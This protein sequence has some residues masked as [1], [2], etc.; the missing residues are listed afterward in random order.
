MYPAELFAI[1][2]A[3]QQILNRP[4]DMTVIFTDSLSAIQG[5]QKIYPNHPVLEQIKKDLVTLQNNRKQLH[6]V[7]IPSHVRIPGNEIADQMSKEACKIERSDNRTYQIPHS[8][9]KKC[10][11]E[12]TKNWIRRLQLLPNNKLRQANPDLSAR[13]PILVKRRDQVVLHCIRIGHIR[14][15]HEH[16]RRKELPRICYACDTNITVGHIVIDCPLNQMERQVTGLPSDIYCDLDSAD[17]DKIIRFLKK[18][19]LY[20]QL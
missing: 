20:N 2:K 7:W 11:N 19:K 9:M 17:C 5:I 10:I 6:I 12:Y 16:L 4:E 8:D 14:L 13:T 18:T 15:T 3:V 1:S